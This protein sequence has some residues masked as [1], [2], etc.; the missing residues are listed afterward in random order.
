MT[1]QLSLTGLVAV[2]TGASRSIGRATA[3]VLAEWGAD[4]LLAARDAR[5]LEPVAAQVDA[6]GRRSLRVSCDVANASQV[7]ELISVCTSE[8]GAP[9]ILIANAGIFQTWRPTEELSLEDWRRIIDVDLTGTLLT[10]QSTGREMIRAGRG[11]AIVLISSVAA[12]TAIP[13]AA[14]YAAAKAGVAGLA[15]TLACEWA[16]HG[17]R[18][19]AIAPGFI[20]RDVDP[21]ESRPGQLAEIVAA[22]PLGRRGEPHEVA[23]AAAFLAS[24]AAGYITGAVLPVDGGWSAH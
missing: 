24:P 12:L 6:L 13:G 22:T 16:E 3:L 4:V 18:V 14:A 20:R 2:I 1:S 21:W 10:C 9:D 23:L 8:L 19:N 7:S 17:I 11:G 5:A 15:R